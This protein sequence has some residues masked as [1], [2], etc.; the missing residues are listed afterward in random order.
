MHV[1]GHDAAAVVVV[2]DEGNPAQRLTVC[3]CAGGASSASALWDLASFIY[4]LMI[5]FCLCAFNLFVSC[6]LQS[7]PQQTFKRFQK[8]LKDE[9]QSAF[10]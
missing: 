2:A 6:A 8:I 10:S 5:I 1:T 4:L 9:L 3:A 7:Y